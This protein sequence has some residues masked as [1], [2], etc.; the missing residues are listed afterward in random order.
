MFLFFLF[1]QNSQD[2]GFGDDMVVA[3]TMPVGGDVIYND[4]VVAPTKPVGADV[5]YPESPSPT[6]AQDRATTAA[7]AELA[8]A[9]VAGASAAPAPVLPGVFALDARV[10]P[11]GTELQLVAAAGNWT[12]GQFAGS[13]PTTWSALQPRTP[14][15]ASFAHLSLTDTHVTVS[16]RINL[17]TNDDWTLV[18]AGNALEE[19][20][21]EN[22][23]IFGPGGHSVNCQL[24]YQSGNTLALYIVGEDD[25]QTSWVDHYITD[26]PLP[27]P[28][29][30]FHVLALTYSPRDG[31]LRVYQNGEPATTRSLPP[32]VF[33]G[34]MRLGA[35]FT[36]RFQSKLLVARVMQANSALSADDIRTLSAAVALDA[37]AQPLI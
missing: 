7:T 20:V 19:P 31:M 13:A 28:T 22:A 5:I 16:P 21:Y 23:I 37:R 1:V 12:F 26:M 3:P 17:T 35:W 25:Q 10:R 14:A 8:T 33:F 24:R 4:M 2:D 34:F 29:T 9:A 36:G 15:A 30:E 32:N 11:V 27:H 6:T 18:F